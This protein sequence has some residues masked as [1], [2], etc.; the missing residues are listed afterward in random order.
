MA[1]D[2]QPS[3]TTP[4]SFSASVPYFTRSAVL[5]PFNR[6][7]APDWHEFMGLAHRC[8]TVGTPANISRICTLWKMRQRLRSAA[9]G[10][11]CSREVLGNHH[12]KSPQRWMGAWAGSQPLILRS[13][14]SGLLTH[15]AKRLTNCTPATCPRALRLISPAVPI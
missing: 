5:W 12:R 3:A 8:Q 2:Q 6:L 1:F 9:G 11:W 15:T 14:E 4:V 13:K 10:V 7:S